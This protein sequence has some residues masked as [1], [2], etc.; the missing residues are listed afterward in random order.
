MSSAA[1]NLPPIPASPKITVTPPSL[2]AIREE[3][4][5]DDAKLVPE[6]EAYLNITPEAIQQLARLAAN[7][8][9]DTKLALR[10]GVDSGGCHGYQYIMELVEDRGVDDYTMQAEGA[11]PVIVDLMSL[12]MLKGATLHYA[13]ELIGSSFRL[14]DNPQAKEGGNCGC[15]VSW[16]AK[17]QI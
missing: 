2:D 8:P 15:G 7:E 3:G 4:F 6:D 11:L 10:V 1:P 17:E 13:T 5:M 16:E 12:G 14:Q 9:P